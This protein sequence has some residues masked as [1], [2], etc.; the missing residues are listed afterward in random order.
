[1]LPGCRGKA[2][3]EAIPSEPT[4]APTRR[5]LAMHGDGKGLGGLSLGGEFAPARGFGTPRECHT[6]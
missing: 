5:M 6:S 4:V 3:P 2:K 1:M